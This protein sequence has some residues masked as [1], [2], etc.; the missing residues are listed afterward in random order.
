MKSK[1]APPR[2]RHYAQTARA[3]SARLT[4]ERILEAFLARLMT[5]WFDEITLDR[6]AADAGVTVQTV[7][8]RFGGKEGLLAGAVEVLAEQIN[9]DRATPPGDID[10]IVRALYADYERTGDAV[11]RLVALESRQPVLKPFTDI[12]R[13]YHRAWLASAFARSL[14]PMSSSERERALDALYVVTDVHAWRL[15]RREMGRGVQASQG[16][17]RSLIAATLQQFTQI[18][19]KGDRS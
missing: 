12:G 10:A 5:Q 14:E 7:V 6:V 13:R 17:T 9:A 3:E 19:G 2:S 8:R 16:I 4:G 15:L 11:V 18:T 1:T